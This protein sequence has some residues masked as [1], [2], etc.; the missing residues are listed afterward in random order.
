[1]VDGR[2]IRPTEWSTDRMSDRP[3]GRLDSTRLDSTRLDSTR[4]DRIESNGVESSAEVERARA[5]DRGAR[6]R[7][8]I[9]LGENSAA[10]KSSAIGE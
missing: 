8:W 5:R 6:T 1:M 9:G 10:R 7:D 4:L 3:S 2:N